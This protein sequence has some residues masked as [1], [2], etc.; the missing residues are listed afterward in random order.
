ME[1]KK[2][3]KSPTWIIKTH[4]YLNPRGFAGNCKYTREGGEK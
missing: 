1:T 2:W 4:F 3:V